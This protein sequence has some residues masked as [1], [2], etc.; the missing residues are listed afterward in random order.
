M[1]YERKEIARTPGYKQGKQP[2]DAGVVKL[3]TNEN[4]FPPCRAVIE[5]LHDIDPES[6]RRYPPPFADAFREVAAGIHGLRPENVMAVN[7]GDELLRLAITTFVDPGRTIG[8]IEPSYLLYRVLGELHG[9]RVVGVEAASDWLLPRDF[10]AMMNRE[11]AQLT[12]IVNPHAP[13]GVLTSD[14][15]LAELATRLEG[16]LLLDEAYAD[17]VDPSRGYNALK[18]ID[19]CDNLLV[20]RS[21]SKGYSLAGLRFGYGLGAQGLIEPML[22]KTRDSYNVDAVAQKLALTALKNRDSARETWKKVREERGRLRAA[23]IDL[24]MLVP[25]SESNF[26]LAQIKPG[27]VSARR[28]YQ[29]LENRRIF[30]RYF[31][32]PR[33]R[34]HLRISIGTVEQNDRLI[35]ELKEI[36]KG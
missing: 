26:L 35:E 21:L 4:P 18:L 9:G 12:I 27:A 20:L 23:L 22:T 34:D 33:L 14:V 11:K 13:S 3:N 36:L 10:A 32:H 29:E 19:R 1:G 30:V 6:L 2:T 15:A 7:G 5:A 16:V 17:F 28:V 8:I 25:E 24:G 31:D